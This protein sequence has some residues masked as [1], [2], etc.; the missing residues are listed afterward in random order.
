MSVCVMCCRLLGLCV[1]V[2]WYLVIDVENALAHAL[3]IVLILI[4]FDHFLSY[5]LSFAV[6]CCDDRVLVSLR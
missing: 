4:W 5:L 6:L 2:C 1:I 3:A